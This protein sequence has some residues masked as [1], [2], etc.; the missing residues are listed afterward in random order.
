MQNSFPP[1]NLTHWNRRSNNNHTLFIKK[2]SQPSV[3]KIW[4][5]SFCLR[6]APFESPSQN[7]PKGRPTRGRPFLVRRTGFPACG[8]ASARLWSAPGTPFTPAPFESLFL[9][10]PKRT[11]HKGTSFFGTPDGIRTHDLWLRRPTLY[12]AEL[13]AHMLSQ[14]A[15]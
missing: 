2:P 12:P 4:I 8:R 13:P 1:R 3:R 7:I 11:S 6:A 10:I 9:N 15:Y 14:T 5:G